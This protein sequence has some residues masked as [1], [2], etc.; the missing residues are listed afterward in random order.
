MRFFFAI[1][2]FFF[3]CEKELDLG[4]PASLRAEVQQQAKAA[5]K[6][7]V[8]QKFDE[9][10]LSLKLTTNINDSVQLYWEPNWDNASQQVIRDTLT[11][12]YVPLHA[13]IR[14]V[15]TNEIVG[16]F[17]DGDNKEYLLAK[18]NDTATVFYKATYI[19]DKPTSEKATTVEENNKNKEFKSFTGILLLRD[20]GNGNT[21]QATYKNGKR[22]E[23][24]K[25]PTGGKETG[26]VSSSGYV[27]SCTVQF[28]CL[29]SRSCPVQ[30]GWS[31]EGTRTFGIDSC[32]F[33][34]NGQGGWVGC[35]PW[36]QTNTYVTQS[37]T[38]YWVDDPLSPTDPNLPPSG[39][40]GTTTPTYPIP[41][42]TTLLSTINSKPYSLYNIPCSLIIQWVNL[43]KFSHLS[44]TSS[45]VHN[46]GSISAQQFGASTYGIPTDHTYISDV[47]D[48]NDAYSSIVNLDNY[49]IKV[50]SLPVINGQRLT[51]QQFL[52]YIRL[53]L[54]SFVNPTSENDLPTFTPY[55]HFG[56]DDRGLWNSSNPIGAVISIDILLNDGSVITSN[57][58]PNSWTFSTIQDP[59]NGRHPVS[60]NREFGFTANADGSYTFYTRGVDRIT[61]IFTTFGNYMTSAPGVGWDG[62]A[63]EGA[64]AAWTSFQK[65]VKDFI[66]SHQ[67]S[68]SSST[69][70][71][72]R[73]DWATVKDVAA[74]RKP[75]STLSNDCK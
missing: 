72:Y 11:Y 65:G 64:D 48:I 15:K 44:T 27:T 9:L 38:T 21:I 12:T 60:G 31:V 42:T 29:F 39:G 54:N 37:C 28:E 25:L 8:R 59:W 61:D 73:P 43:A 68:A 32:P 40:G 50:N 19:I 75:L 3:G 18:S 62:L 46:L 10:H 53:N 49:S 67:G 6:E 14:S 22:Q 20:L 41:S 30:Y 26:D 17:I 1:T 55:N 66:N 57:Y 33:P 63:Y 47:L 23:E 71:I 70:I 4:N 56:I 69:P 45:K 16:N 34:S 24:N 51:P 13:N 2:T 36:E 35:T 58:T 74:G 5:S 7:L 52:N